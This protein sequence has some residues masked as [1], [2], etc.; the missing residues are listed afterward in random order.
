MFLAIV[1]GA[2]CHDSSGIHGPFLRIV[3]VAEVLFVNLLRGLS[4][5]M[6]VIVLRIV[7]DKCKVVVDRGALSIENLVMFVNERGATVVKVLVLMLMRVMQSQVW[8]L[9]DAFLHREVMAMC[10]DVVVSSPALTT[11]GGGIGGVGVDSVVVS[12]PNLLRVNRVLVGG[13]HL[14]GCLRSCLLSRYLDKTVDRRKERA[15]KRTGRNAKVVSSH[16]DMV[17]RCSNYYVFAS[18]AWWVV[19]ANAVGLSSRCP[20]WMVAPTS[21]PGLGE[22][23]CASLNVEWISILERPGE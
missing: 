7:V 17:E 13:V 6:L 16:G 15:T 1:F 23:D 3:R 5:L 11:L 12:H 8:V 21:L 22:C 2:V 14:A 19:S 4:E 9:V 10:G 18:R 20:K